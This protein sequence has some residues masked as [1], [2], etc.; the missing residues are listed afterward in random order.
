MTGLLRP[1]CFLSRTSHH[2]HS[3]LRCNIE[4][5]KC[6][7]GAVLEMKMDTGVCDRM[8]G[9]RALHASRS[10]CIALM[11]MLSLSLYPSPA[12][13][14]ASWCYNGVCDEPIYKASGIR[15]LDAGEVY[16]G[17][18]HEGWDI[19]STTGDT[20]VFANRSGYLYLYP[21]VNIVAIKSDGRRWDQFTHIKPLS[22]LRNGQW[23][24]AGQRLGDYGLYGNTTTPHIHWER[25]L[26][27]ESEWKLQSS[28]AAYGMTCARLVG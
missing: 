25:W 5:L 19:R 3:M 4:L 12:S 16:G 23:V 24:R 18:P 13:A 7:M 20:R 14:G 6:K 17:Q 2:S 26:L 8:Q 28:C 1:A 27:I 15:L 21:T 10:L 11:V 22:T 9:G